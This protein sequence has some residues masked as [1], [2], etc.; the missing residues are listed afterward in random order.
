MVLKAPAYTAIV[1]H[2]AVSHM[3]VQ[4]FFEIAPI[5]APGRS[6]GCGY[7]IWTYILKKCNA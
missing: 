3:A 7:T 4:A 1:W 6:Q 2:V 5:K